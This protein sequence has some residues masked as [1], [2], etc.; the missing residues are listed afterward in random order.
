VYSGSFSGSFFGGGSFG[1]QTLTLGNGLT[2]T[3][4]NG[5][6]A[7][8]AT[9]DTS[10]A[11][12]TNGIKAKLNTDTVVSSSGQVD[13]NTTANY[14]ADQHVA[15]TSVAI[16]GGDGMS[17]GGF[18]TAN[19]T[20]SLNTGS[21][22]FTEGVVKALPAGT[23]SSS[24][25]QVVSTYT[26][27]T[28]NYILTSTGASGINAESTLLYDGTTF[29]ANSTNFT[30]NSTNIT[31]GNDAS[32]VVGIANNTMYV[33]NSKVGIGTTA[34][35]RKL[36]VGAVIV[37]GNADA[38]ADILSEGGI[39]IKGGSWLSL[40]NGY[41]I[42]GRMRYDSSATGAQIAFKLD[43]YYGFDFQTIGA[44]SRMVIRGDNGNVGIGT[45]SPQ[46]VLDVI[47]SANDFASVG[48]AQMSVGQWAGIHFGYR[49]ANTNYRKSAIVF[50]RTD[51]GGG[52]G[53][54]AG[55]VHILNGPATGAGSATLSDARL[56][57]GETGKVGIG[58]TTPVET[59]HV[60]GSA[61]YLSTTSDFSA[62][63]AG[64]GL[65][66]A[67]GAATGN[68][69]STI[70]G[71]QSGGTSYANLIVPG[72]NVGIGTTAPATK[73]HIDGGIVR[74]NT[75]V[76]S[77][78]V[79]PL[80]HYTPGETVFE[81]NT[82]WTDAELQEYFNSANVSWTASNDAPGGYAI[83]V[84]GAVDVGGEYDS[85]FPYIPVD[86]S[87]VFYMECWIKNVGND[88]TH[89]MGSMDYDHNLSSRLKQ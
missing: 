71:V 20:L 9:V 18:I 67:R 49:E 57:I 32:D 52:G 89:Y 72:G 33:N 77:G 3:S 65:I 17:G 5:S 79:Y 62:S 73:L 54:A 47:V 37:D 25:Q 64:S 87:D 19:R 42:H 74:T 59:L 11:H 53:N 15:H 80:G 83:Y 44:T 61:V 46:K 84:N 69:Y 81:M 7:V 55:K 68:T 40:D 76:S 27:G 50:E 12:F 14:F 29:T 70:Y 78:E 10:S 56:T 45:T 48:T 39:T 30:V 66:V 35:N 75:R 43:S 60:Q 6:A 16:L 26:N 8:T 51:D 86:T 85:G 21:S 24:T 82:T 41:T 28:D 88:Q 23:V 58:T 38:N 4:Y 36:Q 13:H 22:H 31:V 1:G 2:G 63:S 34:P